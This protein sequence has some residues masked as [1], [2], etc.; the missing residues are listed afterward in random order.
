[1]L[2]LAFDL[3]ANMFSKT[4]LHALDRI[5]LEITTKCNTQGIYCSRLYFQRSKDMPM[6]T[7]YGISSCLR[8]ANLVYLQ[9][10]G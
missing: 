5:Q 8:N 3:Y 6:A 10:W 2:W 7:F 1:M 4:V 9:G